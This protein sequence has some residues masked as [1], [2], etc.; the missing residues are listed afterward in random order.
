MKIN[1][2]EGDLFQPLLAHS[3]ENEIV[4]VPHVVND[5]GAWGAGFVVPLGK[6]FPLARSEYLGW[7]SHEDDWEV[8]HTHLIPEPGEFELGTAQ[9]VQVREDITICNMLAQEGIGTSLRRLRYDALAQCMMAVG[10]E[11]RSIRE[12][13]KSPVIWAPLFGAGLAGGTWAFIEALITDCWVKQGVPVTI[14][15]LRDY[16]PPDW[17][18]P[19]NPE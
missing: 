2:T 11:A 19:E 7:A 12:G 14:Y 9:F 6:H 3:S 16:L 18:P 1:Y 5:V 15:Y 4:I 17:S 8:D 13:G 10:L